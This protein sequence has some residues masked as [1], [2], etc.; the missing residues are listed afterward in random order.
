[1]MFKGIP[2]KV[3]PTF[4]LPAIL[5]TDSD[6]RG[7]ILQALRVGYDNA[8][9]RLQT[10]IDAHDAKEIEEQKYGAL[11]IAATYASLIENLNLEIWEFRAL[12]I[13][14]ILDRFNTLIP[15]PKTTRS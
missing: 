9:M 8:C 1:M 15:P 2:P 3:H 13:Q 4:K 11:G 7:K 10:A 5:K 12:G 6:E 14:S